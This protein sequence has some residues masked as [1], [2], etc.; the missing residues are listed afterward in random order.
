MQP[1]SN[2]VAASQTAIGS[3]GVYIVGG[4]STPTASSAVFIATVDTANVNFYIDKYYDT[5]I[6]TLDPPS[7]LGDFL[8]IRSYVFVETLLGDSVPTH[9]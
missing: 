9:P 4:G 6:V 5:S 3:E 2:S 8:T 1:G 7:I